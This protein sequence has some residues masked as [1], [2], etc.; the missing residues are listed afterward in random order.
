MLHKKFDFTL[1]YVESCIY[2]L[3]GKDSNSEVTDS[4][5]KYCIETDSWTSIAPVHKKR[6]AS[7]AT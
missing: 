6:Y 4:C 2:V 7:S 3:C 5:E 1:C